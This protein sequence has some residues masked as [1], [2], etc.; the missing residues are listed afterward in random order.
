MVVGPRVSSDAP[1]GHSWIG[2][3]PKYYVSEGWTRKLA[4]I[5]SLIS[6]LLLYNV[7]PQSNRLNANRSEII[8]SLDGF[9][10]HV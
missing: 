1:I 3:V 9:L 8:S 5:R 10:A 2:M 7:T 4:R 6:K